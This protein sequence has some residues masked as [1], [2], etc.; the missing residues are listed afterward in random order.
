MTPVIGFIAA[1]HRQR[2]GMTLLGYAI[3]VRKNQAV[4]SGSIS[5]PMSRML[6][7]C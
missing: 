5:R 1:S 3:G 4:M 2:S 6:C 7:E